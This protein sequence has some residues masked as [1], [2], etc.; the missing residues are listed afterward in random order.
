MFGRVEKQKCV[1]A[2][3][4]LLSSYFT[5]Y[6]DVLVIT[7]ATLLI[8]SLGPRIDYLGI[9]KEFSPKLIKKK[10][11]ECGTTKSLRLYALCEWKP[12]SFNLLNGLTSAHLVLKLFLVHSGN[13]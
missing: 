3:G 12:F 2:E 7:R 5:R 8:R 1:H 6:D 13:S 9:R 10:K 4:S 11:I